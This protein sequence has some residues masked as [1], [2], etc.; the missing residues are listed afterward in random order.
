MAFIGIDLRPIESKKLQRELD[1]VRDREERQRAVSKEIEKGIQENPI[2][3]N[4]FSID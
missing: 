1:D 4:Q 3:R 2:K